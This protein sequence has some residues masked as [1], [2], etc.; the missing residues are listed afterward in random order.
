MTTPASS[1]K[2]GRLPSDPARLARMIELRFTGAA[3]PAHPVTADYLATI[4]EFNGTTNFSY[5]TCGPCSVANS[6]IVTWAHELGL[7]VSVA[8]DDVYDLYRRSGN[9]GFDPA[10]DAGD[11]GVDMTVMLDALVKGGIWLTHADGTRELAKPLAYAKYSAANIDALRAATS[12]FGGSLLAVDLQVAQQQQ[13]DATPAVWDYAKSAD[14]GGHAIYGGAYTSE[15]G[16]GQADESVVSWTQRVGVT[17]AFMARQ[18]QETYIVVW[19]ATWANPNF[20]AGVDQEALETDFQAVTGRAFPVPG[21][22]PAPTPTPIP[23]PVIDPAD[24]AL[25][26]SVQHWATGEHHIGDNAHAAQ[27]VRNWAQAK[28]L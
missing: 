12:I 15:T 17:D 4:P 27:S 5:G 10:T 3:L 14:W 21:P 16:A 13:T 6:A 1:R 26:A 11:G 25:W 23:V 20:Q 19:P 8:D 24:S 9:P 18:L 28:G 2:L 7:T 22:V